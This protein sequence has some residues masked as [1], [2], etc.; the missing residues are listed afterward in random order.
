MNRKKSISLLVVGVIM[1]FATLLGVF[2]AQSDSASTGTLEVNS[3]SLTSSVDLK[4]A[5]QVISTAATDCSSISAATYIENQTVQPLVFSNADPG[6][7]LV[8]Y[9]CVKNTGAESANINLDLFAAT[10]TDTAC[11]GDELTFDAASCGTGAGEL[12]PLLNVDVFRM[13]SAATDN[14]GCDEL[15]SLSGATYSGGIV[16]QTGNAIGSIG[17]GEYACYRIDVD[18][19]SI[20]TSGDEEQEAQSDRVTWKFRFNGN[21]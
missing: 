19:P 14:V 1:T 3:S 20:G 13:G 10:N 9:V 7:D 8:R 16:N 17:A 21:A 5:D 18:Y 6:D 4:I 11:T 15:I 12:G 2:A